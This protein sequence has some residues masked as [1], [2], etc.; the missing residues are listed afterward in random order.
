MGYTISLL[1]LSFTVSVSCFCST[2]M[3]HLFHQLETLVPS[4]WNIC[5]SGMKL[6]FHRHETK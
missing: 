6:L 1:S 4:A 5:S 3:E 2:G